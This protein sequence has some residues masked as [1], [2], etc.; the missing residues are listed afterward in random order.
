[1][2]ELVPGRILA[3]RFELRRLLG[4]G[5]MGQV[6]LAADSELQDQVAVKILEPSLAA[7]AAMLE[8]LRQECRQARRLVHRNIVRIYDVHNAEGLAFISMEFVEGGELGQ[9]RDG[10]PADIVARILPLT[11]ALA[12]AHAMGIVHRDVKP[13]NVLIDREGMPR[14]VD[15][16]IAGVIHGGRALKVSGGGSPLSMSPQQRAGLPPSPADDAFALGIMIYELIAGFPP[17]VEIDGPPPQPLR[18]RTNYAV[19]RRLQ[20]LVARLLV[21]DAAARPSDMETVGKELG[22]VLEDLRNR[23]RPPEVEVIPAGAESEEIAPAAPRHTSPAAPVAVAVRPPTRRLPILVWTAFALLAVLLVG[24]VFFLPDFVAQQQ[25]ATVT[26]APRRAMPE[27]NE[28]EKAAELKARAEEAAGQ[29]QAMD[30]ELLARG[31]QDWG[32]VDYRDAQAIAATAGEA[33]TSGRYES[34]GDAWQRAVSA[35]EG[36]REKG[37]ELLRLSLE[38]GAEALRE[39]RRDAAEREFGMALVLD[40]GN[41]VASAGLGRA[42]NIE[43]VFAAYSDGVRLEQEGDLVAALARYR[44]VMELDPEFAG[45]SEAIPRVQA[46][47]VE[48]RYTSAMSEAYA[49]LADKHFEDAIRAFETASRIR[50]SAAEPAEGITRAREEK[51]V[52]EIADGRSRAQA[53]EAAEKWQEALT[54]YRSILAEDGAVVFAQSGSRRAGARAALD[55]RLQGLIDD[56]ERM[57]SA[58]VQEAARSALA[59]AATIQQPGPRLQGQ[60]SRVENLLTE[61]VRPVRVTLQSDNLTEVVLY[62]VGRLGT[63]DQFQL[64]LRPGTY[65]AVGTRK[66]FRDVRQQF[67]VHPGEPAGPYTIRCEERI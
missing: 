23:T 55:A 31:V 35:L 8:L 61:A 62:Q 25:P 50:P 30:E 4:R 15:F 29:F 49:S 18:S 11:S 51:R 41:P 10:S 38:R 54:V 26:E 44:E 37:G 59:Q 39:G 24:V 17:S 52:A 60:I 46:A 27:D 7:D 58:Q 48:R 2:T 47:M 40:P 20:A 36:L 28:L 53:L 33:L 13:S 14:L 45:P 21:A 64:E 65:T 43:R 6:W 3:S 9:L 67:T 19:P 42:E 12:Y 56:P 34:A 16:G 5:G 63:F 1:M 22:A 57:Y 66:G 32:G